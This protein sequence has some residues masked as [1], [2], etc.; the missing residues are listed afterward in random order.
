MNKLAVV[1][2]VLFA[3][4]ISVQAQA[5]SKPVIKPGGS[6]IQVQKVAAQVDPVTSLQAQV[7]VLRSQ[8]QELKRQI[9]IL[10]KDSQTAKANMPR[11]SEDLRTSSSALGSR[12]C[13]PYACDSVV[14]TCLMSCATTNDCSPGNVCDI[15][16]ARCVNPMQQ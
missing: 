16:A 3:V 10:V 13:S 14:G 7:R 11:C 6:N 15:Q 9:D 12:E 4:F 5:P 8:V 2:V 1:V